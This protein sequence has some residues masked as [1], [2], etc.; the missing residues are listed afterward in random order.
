MLRTRHNLA[1]PFWRVPSP[2]WAG[3]M[4]APHTSFPC[5]FFLAC[6]S[7]LLG[8]RRGALRTRH[9]LAFSFWRVPPPSWAGKEERS[10]HVISLLFLF[11][12]CLRPLGLAKG[13]LRTRHNLAF[14]FL[15]CASALLGWRNGCSAHVISLLFLFGV[16]L[17]PFVLAKGTL[18]T[19]QNLAFSFWRVP[20]PSWAGKMAAP[21]TSFPCFFFLACASALLYWRKERSAHVTIL[22]FLFGVCLRPLGLAKWL[23]RTRHNLAFSFWRVP[24]LSCNGE[25]DAPHTSQSCFYFLTC[26]SAL[27][28]WRK[29]CS[30]HVI[31]LLF[32]FGVCRRPLVLAKGALRTRQNFAFSFWRVPPPSW[33]GEE[34]APHT[35]QSCFFFLACASALL[36]WRNGC[37]AH[38]KT[39]LFLFDVC[40]RPLG[41]AKWLLRTRHFTHFLKTFPINLSTTFV[42]IGL[43]SDSN[44]YMILSP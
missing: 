14:S 41:L 44:V 3:E 21:H 2:S 8:W 31:S 37:P 12:V 7:A 11:G 13:M 10:A 19:R 24:V 20:V 23:P 33:A 4:A 30:A 28:C 34:D 42:F 16:C 26:A 35:S 9:F 22:L 36:G 43:S 25:R 27:L 38:V 18:R 40:L 29:G 1:F 15:A 6:A 5:F 17:R 32:L 39:L